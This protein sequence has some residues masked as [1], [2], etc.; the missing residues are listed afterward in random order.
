[1]KKNFFTILI[2]TLV[3][4]LF[5]SC[6]RDTFEYIRV[7]SVTLY[8]TSLTLIEGE[9]IMLTA[10]VYPENTTVNPRLLWSSNN[11]SIATVDAYGN[12]TAVRAGQ[13]TISVYRGGVCCCLRLAGVTVT[14]NS[15]TVTLSPALLTLAEGEQA[16]LT[17]TVYPTNATIANLRWSSSNEWIA[18]VDAN[19]RVTAVE[20]GQAVIAVYRSCLQGWNWTRLAESTVTV[21]LVIP[22][23][24]VSGVLVGGVRWAT[25]NVGSPGMFAHAPESFGSR[26]HWNR[27]TAQQHSDW[28]WYGNGAT[29]WEREND[30]CPQGWRVPTEAELR[31][32]TNANSR[33]VNV[34]GVNGRLFG[35]APNHI[36]L[37]SGNYWSSTLARSLWS[38][39][40]WSNSFVSERSLGDILFVRCV[41]N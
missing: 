38:G 20:Q 1:M 11:S 32:L 39:D 3:T 13:T 19:G 41:A 36:F 29:V 40:S 25:R 15:P 35:V 17:K 21:N 30:P 27:R 23:D 10:T 28:N 8:P 7:Q 5:A 14:V 2:V 26:F 6:A 37:P 24:V 9:Q 22:D 33:W 12:V 31:I 16:T 4:I 34:N 18:T